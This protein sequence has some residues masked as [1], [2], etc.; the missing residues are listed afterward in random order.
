MSRKSLA[1]GVIRNVRAKTVASCKAS[2][3]L[4]PSFLHWRVFLAPLAAVLCELRG[5]KFFCAF[6]AKA[7]NRKDRKGKR[8]RK[9]TKKGVSRENFSAHR[10]AA[11]SANYC[12]CTF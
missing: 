8:K 2:R 6:E 12:A 9:I 7:S 11:A 10:E 3:G 4:D 1:Q 5:Y